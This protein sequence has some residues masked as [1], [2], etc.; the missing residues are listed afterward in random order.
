M[1]FKGKR[2]WITGATSGIGRA[3]AIE[4]SQRKTNLILSGRN[5]SELETVAE[6][7]RNAGSTVTTVPFDLANEKEIIAASQQVLQGGPIDALYQFGGISQRSFALDTPVA[8][9][10][11]IMEINFFG[12][13]ILTKSILPSMIANGG[14]HIGITSSVVGKFGFPYRSAYSASKHALHGFFESLRAENTNK[15]IRI[16]LII[17]GRINTNISFNALDSHGLKH[18]VLDEGQATGWKVERASMVICKGL[19]SE[20]KEIL[21]GGK[22]VLMVYIRRFLPWLYYRL[23]PNV[24]PL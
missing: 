4:I 22:S 21:F 3:V 5:L 14:G 20:K 1:D 23:A 9:D 6:I 16:S 13:I 19:K 24:K 15:N 12:T 11:I 7:C 8:I 2:V 18:G 17:P 10:R